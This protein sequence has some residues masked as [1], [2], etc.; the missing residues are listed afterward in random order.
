MSYS[1]SPILVPSLLESPLT[2]PLPLYPRDRTRN[3]HLPQQ[4]RPILGY[5]PTPPIYISQAPEL[6][7]SLSRSQSRTSAA[8]HNSY[9]SALTRP[10]GNVELIGL[11]LAHFTPARTSVWTRTCH[12]NRT[13]APA[14]V[15]PM[16]QMACRNDGVE[17]V[18]QVRGGIETMRMRMRMRA[19]RGV[20]GSLL[21]AELPF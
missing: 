15:A 16:W 9:R 2:W 4:A 19:E 11:P 18:R 13:F 17:S 6:S 3:T 14:A 5:T 12:V 10:Q 1:H 8:S 7:L 20:E 21:P